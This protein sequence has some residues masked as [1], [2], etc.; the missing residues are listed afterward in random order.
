MS[1]VYPNSIRQF[2]KEKALRG[3]EKLSDDGQF[4]L[5]LIEKALIVSNIDDNDL[6][7]DKMK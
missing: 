1:T 5:N 6:C 4:N 2:I 7:P 3:P